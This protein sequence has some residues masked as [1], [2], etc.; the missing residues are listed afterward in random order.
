M[1]P[2]LRVR[3]GYVGPGPVIGSGPQYV[4]G[5]ANGGAYVNAPFGEYDFLYSL[6]RMADR[7]LE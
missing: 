1:A 7:L 3:G 5:G 4:N 2:P 6:A